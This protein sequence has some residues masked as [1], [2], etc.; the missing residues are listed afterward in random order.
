MTE[1]FIPHAGVQIASEPFD[2]ACDD[3]LVEED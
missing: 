1:P 2:A 3:G